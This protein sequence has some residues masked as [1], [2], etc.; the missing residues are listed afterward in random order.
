[1]KK[2]TIFAAALIVL[3]LLTSAATR[4]KKSEI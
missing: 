3:S 2:L 1:M 4:S